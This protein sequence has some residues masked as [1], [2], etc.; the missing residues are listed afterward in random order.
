MRFSRHAVVQPTMKKA[1]RSR[2]VFI[3][4]NDIIADWE[5]PDNFFFWHCYELNIKWR[6]SKVSHNSKKDHSYRCFTWMS[7][8][9]CSW[10]CGILKLALWLKKNKIKKIPKTK[11]KTLK[12]TIIYKWVYFHLGCWYKKG[13]RQ[14]QLCS[15]GQM[16]QKQ[17]QKWFRTTNNIWQVS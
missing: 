16:T 11:Q 2:D 15:N 12:M 5:G 3:R 6:V 9:E 4:L 14:D 13:H 1:P 17:K 10:K 8:L 7:D